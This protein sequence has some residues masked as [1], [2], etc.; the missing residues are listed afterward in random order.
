MLSGRHTTAWSHL[1]RE[2]TERAGTLLNNWGLALR[3]LGQPR[4]AERM[5]RR[6]VQISSADASASHVEPILWNNLARAVFDLGRLP[7]AIAL[8][9]RAVRRGPYAKVTR[10]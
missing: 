10:W 3:A 8:V 9:E 6:S 1:G 7:E 2:D 4:E 5:F